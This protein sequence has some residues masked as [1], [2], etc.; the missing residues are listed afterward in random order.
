MTKKPIISLIAAIGKNRELGFS[1]KLIWKIPEDLKFFRQATSSHPVI[2]G[3]KT[4]E[5]I[6]RVLPKRLNIILTKDSNFNVEGA[7][8]CHSIEQALERA[9]EHDREEVFVIGG[10]QIYTQTIDRA[11]RLYLTI[12]DQ[13]SKADTYFP[14]YKEFKKSK[15]LQSG[16]YEGTKY[17]IVQFDR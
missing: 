15:K 3:Q 13:S 10:G 7:E 12:I 4:F 11:D 17:S 2:M 5:S 1:N 16:E 6:G 8:V 14:E 9:V